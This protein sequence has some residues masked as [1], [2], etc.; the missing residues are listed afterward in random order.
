MNP[1]LAANPAPKRSFSTSWVGKAKVFA[2]APW[3]C[4][5]DRPGVS[6]QRTEGPA[7]SPK[8]HQHCV[9]S[10]PQTPTHLHE[11]RWFGSNSQQFPRASQA[12]APQAGCSQLC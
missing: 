4:S 10:Q 3:L 12:G 5:Q 7:Y 8:Y 1:A 2:T 11:P 6:L 9:L